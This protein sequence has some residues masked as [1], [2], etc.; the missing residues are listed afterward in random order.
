MGRNT[1]F[2][3][4]TDAG[5]R[6]WSALLSQKI[7]E[8]PEAYGL[9][10]QQCDSFSV[11]Q[12]EYASAL[13]IATAPVTRTKV[14]VAQKNAARESLKNAARLIN[15]IVKGQANVSDAQMLALG[16]TVPAERSKVPAPVQMPLIQVL[17][18]VGHTVQIKFRRRDGAG[19]AWPVGVEG[20]SIFSFVGA[21]PAENI[22]EFRFEMNV[23]SK[24]VDVNFPHSL[25][26]G[27]TVWLTARYYNHRQEYGPACP[28]IQTNLQGG[29][30][31]MAA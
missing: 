20:A 19:R 9:D 15:S 30:I 12:A 17:S 23:T 18:V 21:Q 16:F 10:Q 25:K 5:L 13:Q 31:V 29:M 26:P 11:V 8:D 27:T 4:S 1:T 3:P 14:S 28:A 22:S 7:T 6:A 2:L 24:I